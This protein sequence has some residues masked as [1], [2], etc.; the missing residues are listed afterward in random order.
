[1][2][3]RPLLSSSPPGSPGGWST[4]ASVAVGCTR[5]IVACTRS[6]IGRT[7]ATRTGWPPCSRAGRA[8]C[9]LTVR[10][11]PHTGFGRAPPRG[12]TSPHR[13]GAAGSAGGFASMPPSS[14]RSTRPSSVGSRSRRCPGRSSTSAWSSRRA[15]SSTRSTVRN[16]AE[17]SI[18]APCGRWSGA[19]PPI[20][21]ARRGCG[22]SSAI[23]LHAVDARTR[24][25][26]ERRFLRVCRRYGVPM[27]RVNEWIALPIAPGGLEVDFSWPDRRLIVEI[28]EP[29]T[30]DTHRA[31]RNDPARDRALTAAGWRPM[32]FPDHELE[33]RPA[34]VAAEVL[35]AIDVSGAPLYPRPPLW[36]RRSSP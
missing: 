36:R 23:R 21:A 11:L 29:L 15:R 8:P 19:C 27:P 31:R 3:S 28:D 20:T 2:G 7:R 5:C 32:R 13:V 18:S 35:A 33:L 1:M 17:S 6:G 30:H 16:R 10:R 26:A 4:G 9:S 22:R 25:S 14:P 12:S 24:G 34:G